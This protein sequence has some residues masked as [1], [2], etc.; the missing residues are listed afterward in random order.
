MVKRLQQLEKLN[1]SLKSELK[2]KNDI[3]YS[4]KEENKLLAQAASADSYKEIAKL[5]LE[6]DKFKIQCTE[7]EKFLKDYGLKWVGGEGG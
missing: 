1:Q 6:R 2:E 7:M 3:C 4:L 5:T